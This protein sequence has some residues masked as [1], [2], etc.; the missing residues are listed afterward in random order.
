MLFISYYELSEE[1]NVAERLQAAQKIM[2]KGLYPPKGVNV[3]RWDVTPD[4]WGIVVAET[5]SVAALNDA[6]GVWR[7]ASPGF[8]KMIKTSPAMPVQEAI[9]SSVALLQALG[10]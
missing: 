6:I 9:P 10:S 3:L 1:G 2:A 5:D 7:A 8:F 4:G